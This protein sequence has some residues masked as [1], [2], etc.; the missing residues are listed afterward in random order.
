MNK[1]SKIFLAVFFG[2]VLLSIF[3]TWYKY[4]VS[5]D[6]YIQAES[7][8]NPE[9]EACFMTVCDPEEDEECPEDEFERARYYKLIRK[10]AYLFPACDPENPHCPPLK[11]SFGERNCEET[12]C[13]EELLEEGIVCSDPEQYLIEKEEFE[14]RS[15]EAEEMSEGSEEEIIPE[16]E[17]AEELPEEL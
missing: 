15:L 2:A 14:R 5:L 1:K 16:E 4:F 8:C 11:C 12:F 9:S 13:S 17:V 3:F 7:R 6:Y 10:K